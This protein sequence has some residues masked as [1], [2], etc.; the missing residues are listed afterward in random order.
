M[1]SEQSAQKKLRSFPD[2]DG[3]SEGSVVN[4]TVCLARAYRAGRSWKLN[5]PKIAALNAD[6]RQGDTVEVTINRRRRR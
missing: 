5:I 4:R 2:S 6:L 3:V 1:S